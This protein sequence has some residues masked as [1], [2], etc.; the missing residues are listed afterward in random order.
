M[1]R[2]TTIDHLDKDRITNAIRSAEAKTAGEI[3]CVIARQSDS[4]AL[5]PFVWASTIALV[6]PVP[7]II[8]AKLPV[9]QVYLA[10]LVIFLLTVLV[11]SLPA[12]R[13]RVVPRAI[14]NRHAHEE[15][16]RQ[17]FAQGLYKTEQR[18]GVLIFAS[19]AERYAEIVADSGINEKVSAQVWKDAIT[20][21]VDGVKNEHPTDGFVA[22]IECCGMVLAKH[23][24]PG[25]LNRDELPDRVVEI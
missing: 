9:A 20:L 16:V 7:L 3:F 1:V 25:S 6:A 17:F 11:L 8:L 21:L 5:V 4:Y 23:F 14:K 12:I 13:F 10:Q 18:T 19:L 24:P 15:A 22:A 2:R